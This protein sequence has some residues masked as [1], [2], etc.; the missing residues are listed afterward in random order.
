MRLRD[1]FYTAMLTLCGVML[2]NAA[3]AQA[4]T[5]QPQ[6]VDARAVKDMGNGP[7]QIMML[8]GSAGVFTSQGSG[9]GGNGGVSG[10]TLTLTAS[11][12]ANPPC[13]GC[14]ISGTGITPGTTVANFNGTTTV[15]LSAAMTVANGTALSWGKACPSVGVSGNPPIGTPVAMLAAANG[16]DVPFYTG[17]RLCAAGM[18]GPGAQFVTFAI[19]AH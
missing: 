5:Q 11:A 7:L 18:N 3:H 10:V 9:V 8:T 6:Y 19:G 12:A 2:V 4:V 16:A 1:I 17:A 14:Q 15:T 13:I